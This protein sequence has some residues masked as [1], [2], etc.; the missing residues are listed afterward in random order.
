[1]SARERHARHHAT[2]GGGPRHRGARR[3]RHVVPQLLGAIV[4]LLLLAVVVV[5]LIPPDS[6]G[7]RAAARTTGG[8]PANAQVRVAL[9][10]QRIAVPASFLGVSTEY[11]AMPRYERHLRVFER[12]LALLRARGDG[13]FLLR[14]G[15]D[16]ADHT[17]WEPSMRAPPRWVFGLTPRWLSPNTHAGA[18]DRSAADHRP[19]PADRFAVHGSA[20]G[21]RCLPGPSARKHRRVRDR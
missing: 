18:P 17:F 8:T 10:A 16:S 5:P 9:R 14:I 19:E 6:D 2:H 1:M 11:W 7:T 15:G 3:W 12:V 20:V 13:P 21:E 4:A